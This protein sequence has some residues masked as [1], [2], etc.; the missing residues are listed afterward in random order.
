MQGQ[1]P[2]KRS[3]D[4]QPFALQIRN[5]GTEDDAQGLDCQ[6]TT[7][8]I[9]ERAEAPLQTPNNVRQPPACHDECTVHHSLQRSD[10]A[11]TPLLG[12]KKRQLHVQRKKALP[13]LCAH[14]T[15]LPTLSSPTPTRRQEL[16]APSVACR[17]SPTTPR[18]FPKEPRPVNNTVISSRPEGKTRDLT[19]W[20]AGTKLTNQASYFISRC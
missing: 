5:V 20:T 18:H 2:A 10:S 14:S 13:L 8:L 12:S 4:Q 3:S 11:L 9:K 1:P 7:K 17:M 19:N 6:D 15:F 16:A